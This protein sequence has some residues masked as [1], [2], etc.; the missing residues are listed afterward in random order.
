MNISISKETESLCEEIYSNEGSNG[1]SMS[2]EYIYN[3][4]EKIN[5]IDLV[6]FYSYNLLKYDYSYNI[7]LLSSTIN[8]YKDEKIGFWKVLLLNEINT[9]KNTTLVID[10][11]TLRNKYTI[12]IFL[13]KYLEINSFELLLSITDEKKIIKDCLVF[14]NKNFYLL[15]RD[16]EFFEDF[17]DG[18]WEDIQ[19]FN[20]LSE[21]LIKSMSASSS[22]KAIYD[23]E[24]FH[25]YINEK[26][27]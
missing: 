3:Y 18:F 24:K 15:E 17:E 11:F 12:I 25:N 19:N 14:F 13:Y 26:I 5:S 2:Y 7:D 6:E 22:Y 27:N 4:F 1:L 10:F 16:Y 8:L 21:K 23:K 9:I 20:S